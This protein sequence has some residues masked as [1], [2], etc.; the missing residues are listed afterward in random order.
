[1]F[2]QLRNKGDGC[3]I[4]K[5]HF[6]NLK[7][8][9][10]MLFLL[11]ESYCCHV[12]NNG[13]ATHALSIM[14]PILLML[15]SAKKQWPET[16]LWVQRRE[17][18]FYLPKSVYSFSMAK[19]NQCRIVEKGKREIYLSSIIHLKMMYASAQKLQNICSYCILYI[20]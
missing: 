4:T 2:F 9:S 17:M 20:T 8:K 11:S 18:K 12:A 10:F 13:W 5:K 6:L 14:L 15:I 16:G 1:M 19:T 7:K 3:Q